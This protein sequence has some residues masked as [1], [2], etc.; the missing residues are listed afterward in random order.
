[1]AAK[2]EVI[3]ESEREDPARRK[4][5]KAL[6]EKVQRFLV[7]SGLENFRLI[8]EKRIGRGG[9]SPMVACGIHPEHDDLLNK[10]LAPL[11]ELGREIQRDAVALGLATFQDPVYV[12]EFQADDQQPPARVVGD[13]DD[14]TAPGP[15]GAM[16]AVRHLDRL[17]RETRRKNGGPERIDPAS[18]K[19]DGGEVLPEGGQGEGPQPSRTPEDI[20]E[21]AQ[22]C[23]KAARQF[24][25]RMLE[26]ASAVAEELRRCTPSIQPDALRLRSECQMLQWQ[27]RALGVLAD[28][29]PLD[30][31]ALERYGV[32]AAT[33]MSVFSTSHRSRGRPA[34]ESL[35]D[36]S[37]KTLEVVVQGGS[38]PPEGLVEEWDQAIAQLAEVAEN[39]ETT[40]LN[41]EQSIPDEPDR[42]AAIP[43]QG[44]ASENRE[45]EEH[46]GDVPAQLAKLE[47]ETPPLDR[48]SGAWVK[49][50]QAARL[51]GCETDTLRKYRSLGIKSEN[52]TLG[53]DPDG[54]VWRKPG[55][56]NSHA[57]Y[58]ASTLLTQRR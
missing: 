40:L 13:T 26:Y 27:L 36:L 28:G 44:A 32:P 41:G 3:A 31:T 52:G 8:R 10:F 17:L 5:A 4:K 16:A 7:N 21:A 19:P 47:E 55:T 46:V 51:E 22:V 45:D 50:T 20:R 39:L 18:E 29:Q 43:E 48:D 11:D 56:R 9:I 53:R 33:L 42:R 2:A 34:M 25:S 37:E 54:R 24:L 49:G 58:L 14:P 30:V 38:G 23:V 12:S 1:L 6:C 15:A 57:W 35:R